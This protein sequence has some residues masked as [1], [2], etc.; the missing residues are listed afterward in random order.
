MQLAANAPR[1]TN[2][3]G[4]R[5][6]APVPRV[7]FSVDL[8]GPELLSLGLEGALDQVVEVMGRLDVAGKAKE[9]V[10][11]LAGRGL[12]TPDPTVEELGN[13]GYTIIDRA[14]PTAAGTDPRTW[15][16]RSAGSA[17]A[18]PITWAGWNAVG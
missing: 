7:R 8:T 12:L 14:R 15:P 2:L 9:D 1:Q 4:V 17:A 3:E 11:E 10:P 18:C 16:R 5:R 6:A 13:G